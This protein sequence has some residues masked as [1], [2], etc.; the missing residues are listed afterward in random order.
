MEARTWKSAIMVDSSI[1]APRNL[2]QYAKTRVAEMNRA[3]TMK[4]SSS[5]L[6]NNGCSY[7]GT[8]PPHWSQLKI[9]VLFIYRLFFHR[10][11]NVTM[12]GDPSYAK[13]GGD[14]FSTSGASLTTP[15]KTSLP[16]DPR[17]NTF[18]P[19]SGWGEREPSIQLRTWDQHLWH[20]EAQNL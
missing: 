12:L 8:R 15:S 19:I 2:R 17:S 3:K 18:K 6:E 14:D 13:L 5:C 16:T 7:G 20:S 10:T 4:W 9:T 1:K 11:S